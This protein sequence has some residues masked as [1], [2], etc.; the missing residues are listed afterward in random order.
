MNH[1]GSGESAATKLSNF[2]MTLLDADPAPFTAV[3]TGSTARK[4]T[5]KPKKEKTKDKKNPDEVKSSP[6]QNHEQANQSQNPSPNDK[7]NAPDL[8]INIQ[9]H[10]SSDASPDQIKSIFENMAKYLYKN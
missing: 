2:Y 5:N 7:R 8:N 3:K 4:D 9:I 6:Q 1:T 10:I